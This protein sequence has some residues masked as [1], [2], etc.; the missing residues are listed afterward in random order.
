MSSSRSKLPEAR[1][2]SVIGIFNPET[3]YEVPPF[4][5]GY[6]WQDEQ[7]EKLLDDLEKSYVARPAEPYLLGQTILYEDE[8]S[9]R[10]GIVDGQQRLTTLFLF[11]AISV[12]KLDKRKD[13]KRILETK[14]STYKLALLHHEDGAENAI[15]RLHVSGLGRNFIDLIIPIEDETQN[16]FVVGDDTAEESGGDFVKIKFPTA[17]N[18][19]EENI[20]TAYGIINSFL[21]KN[22]PETQEL[23]EF[24]SYVCSRAYV[25]ELR[26]GSMSQAIRTFAIMNHRG[27]ELDDADLIKNL[28]FEKI[29]DPTR[30]N[31]ISVNWDDAQNELF[32][33]RL[34]RVKSMD[35]LLGAMIGVATGESI[36]SND[37]FDEWI[38]FLGS[39]DKALD[40]AKQLPTKA[41]YI[42]NISLG[43]TLTG[44]E[45]KEVFGSYT[46]KYVQH[47]EV[48][49]A[50]EKLNASSYKTLASIVDARVILSQF[51]GEKNQDFERLVHK[52]AHQINNL[53]GNVSKA[54]I[55]AASHDVLAKQD[56]VAAIKRMED[57]LDLLDYGT[58]SHRVKIR[59]F[60][61]RCAR[62]V[63]DKHLHRQIA[64]F[65]DLMTTGTKG[66]PG[67]DIDHIYPKS[68]ARIAQFKLKE[69]PGQPTKLQV[70]NSIGNLTLLHP[71]DNR[72]QG[73]SLPN[74]AGKKENFAG[75]QLF[76][77][78]LLTD[79]DEWG[80]NIK[81]N[82]NLLSGLKQLQGPNPLLNKE[83]DADSIRKRKYFYF[84]LFVE[85]LL[86][87]FGLEDLDYFSN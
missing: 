83:W 5:R 7:V 64:D 65:E 30:F 40:F 33:S 77:N 42:K 34:K 44:E 37:V 51:S 55:V 25:L 72:S 23:F 62:V 68:D 78:A 22:Y 26:L 32:R 50:G 54:E 52:W 41:K 73:D 66:K 43:K 9:N 49:L 18:P 46:M 58:A 35:F 82:V 56:V 69:L 1:G 59:Y 10:L 86:S 4:Q 14:F 19:S 28:L 79:P 75:S 63:Q 71:G 76:I 21:D 80:V 39:E 2:V 84:K 70:L 61:A 15:H 36:S 38:K 8:S 29:K 87:D 17:E 45:A 47:F 24:L 27:R 57:Q 6:A 12:A 85:D 16:E 3:L 48:L 60:L 74:D 53:R 31:E 13:R 11:I 20:E 81:N 67:F